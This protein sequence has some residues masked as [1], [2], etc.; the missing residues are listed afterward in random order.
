MRFRSGFRLGAGVGVGFRRNP[1]VRERPAAFR[2][3]K[4]MCRRSAPGAVRSGVQARPGA[5]R[6]GGDGPDGP[7]TARATG[8]CPWVRA[9]WRVRQSG[10]GKSWKYDRV[11][12]RRYFSRPLASSAAANTL[13]EAAPVRAVGKAGIIVMAGTVV[14]RRFPCPKPVPE[15]WPWFLG[16]PG[17]RSLSAIGSGRRA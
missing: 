7:A 8:A 14:R 17:S 11:L 16:V 3:E 15:C 10:I 13:R 5:P 12:S 4:G 2:R 9:G 1:N 6:R